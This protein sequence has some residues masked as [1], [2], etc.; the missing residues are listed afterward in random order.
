M[1]LPSFPVCKKIINVYTI[2]LIVLLSFLTVADLGLYHAWG[3]RLD[4]TPLQYFNSPNEM[5][6]SIGSSPIVSLIAIFVLLSI[7]FI[8]LYKYA[9]PSVI[10]RQGTSMRNGFISLFLLAVLFIPIRGGLQQIPINQS[11]VYFSSKVYADHAALNMPWNLMHSLL[12]KKLDKTNPYGY[13]P[14][15]EAKKIKDSLYQTQLPAVKILYTQRPNIIFIILES[16]TSKFVGCLG[17]VPGVTP[18]LDSIAA[19][20]MLFTHI[21]ASGDRSEKGL[22]ALL[23]GYPTQTTTS[24]IFDPAKTQNLPGL[25]GSLQ[26]YG[27]HSAY[28]YGG[29]LEFAN[30]KSYLVNQRFQKLVSKKD[31]ASKD[32]NSKWGVHDHILFN[33]LQDDLSNSTQPFFATLFTLSSHEPYEIPIPAKFEGSDE[34]TEFKNS[35]YYTDQALGEFIRNAKTQRWWDSTLIILVADHGH[36]LPGNDDIFNPAKFRIPLVLTG[37]ALKNKHV[38]NDVIGSQTDIAYSL[39]QQM[40]MNTDA[41]KW[42]RNLLAPGD[43]FAFYVFNDGFGF[44]TSSGA[45]AFDNVSRKVIY[46]D[47]AITDKQLSTGKAYMQSSYADFLNR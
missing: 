28:Y 45:F 13:L 35:F 30:I 33:R 8:W 9:V 6:A 43:G 27:Y 24:I 41:Y 18:N 25:Q 7:V 38:V 11:D 16:Y 14:V 46:K 23:S 20:G 4:A 29:E 44:I 40:G 3:F 12:N 32:Y 39:L 47:P 42:S 37:G 26:Q 22:V 17:G 1:D 19:D 10:V 21:Y 36:R 5:R 34:T 31:F 2:T 15:E